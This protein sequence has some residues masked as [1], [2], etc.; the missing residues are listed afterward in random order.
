MTITELQHAAGRGCRFSTGEGIA[1]RFVREEVEADDDT[2]WTGEWFGTGMAVLVM[3]GDDREHVIDPEDVTVIADDDYCHACGQVG[4]THD[5]RERAT[6][7]PLPAPEGAAGTLA[8]PAE[9]GPEE[10]I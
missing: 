1:W 5:G 9:S 7:G 6:G 8:L 4:C 3:I 10:A 2:E